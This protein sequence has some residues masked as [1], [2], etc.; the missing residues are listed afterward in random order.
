MKANYHTHTH[1]CRHAAGTE[2]EYIQAAV[3]SAFQ[4]L[5]F[6]DHAPWPF[7]SGYVSRIRMT[8][9]QLPDYLTTLKALKAQ[10]RDQITLRIGLECEYFT[11]YMDYLKFMREQVDY[12][13][14]GMHW[15]HS[16]ENNP[17]TPDLCQTD[18][19]IKQYADELCRAMASG[20]YAYVAHP[21]LFMR[22]RQEW[23]KT[24]QQATEQIV[25]TAGEYHLPVEYN[26]N[27]EKL[28]RRGEHFFPCREFWAQAAQYGVPA[29][30]GADAH[31]PEL[32]ANTALWNE[33]RDYLTG[34]GFTVTPCLP[35]DA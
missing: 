18:D 8:P 2:T 11:P 15:L 27:G 26:L 4:V 23:N 29:I 28:F 7:A 19:G 31:Q 21:D 13:L 10:Y 25:R 34:L 6:A 3:D 17:Y 32:L 9:D 24:C 35:L 5:G 16:E 1:R 30:L 14:L 22:R 20:L 33:S 12:L